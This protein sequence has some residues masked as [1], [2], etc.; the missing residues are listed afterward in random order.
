M[1]T[2][3]PIIDAR[4]LR[5]SFRRPE[6]QTLLVLDNVDLKIYP[7]EIVALLGK[8][9]SG[10]S[11]LLRILAGLVP[12]S[13]GEVLFKG[14]PLNGPQQGISMVFQSFA[15]MP[16]LT[17]LQNVELGLES[18][19]LDK[20]TRRDRALKAIDMIGLDGF[21]SAYPRE[22][23]GGMQQRVGFARALVV[24][25]K[26]LLMDE[27]FSALDILTA[28]ALRKDLMNIWKAGDEDSPE[29]IL[30]VTHNIE[31]AAEIA[32]RILI[33][34]SDP[35]YLKAE[36]PVRQSYPRVDE[37]YIREVV[38]NVYFLMTTPLQHNKIR[39]LQEVDFDSIELSYRL[40]EADPNQLK[41]LAWAVFEEEPDKALDLPVVAELVA[42]NM[43]DFYDLMEA[44]QILHLAKI[45]RGDL[46]LTDAGRS[47]A[48][49]DLHE[50]KVIFASLLFE[51]VPVMTYIVELIAK[52]EKKR[53][54]EQEV[55]S[56][57]ADSLS[58]SE[59]ERV[60]KVIV[61]WGRFAE[62]FAYNIE[63]RYLSLENPD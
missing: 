22:L 7:R 32:D 61:S 52:S 40:P 5:K 39:L 50:G 38:D 57:L 12:A 4:H 42:L 13:E 2:T 30:L 10:K 25:P 56:V 3:P 41:A 55:L 11:T 1:P 45:S 62:I 26:V 21:E 60:F 47:F 63:S 58:E 43:D 48:Q 37:N 18:L 34:G 15:L 54:D 51:W 49:A 35:G 17:V 27:P 59:A 9:G 36:L 29:A 28:E 53:I 6:G 20:K 31:E 24:R 19:G 46:M 16:W 33:F 8:S 23:S 44:M 14:V